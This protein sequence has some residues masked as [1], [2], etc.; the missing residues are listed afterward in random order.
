VEVWPILEKK[1]LLR[2]GLCVDNLNNISKDCNIS[3][4][5]F[6]RILD[7][8]VRNAKIGAYTFLR[9]GYIQN[10]KSIGRFCSIAKGLLIGMGEHPLT[11]LSSHPFQYESVFPFWENR[12]TLKP[13]LKK[14]K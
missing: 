9:G 13:K 14:S 6:V 7:T 8:Y 11:Y 12:R 2:K 5:P 10:V 1:E 4:E 3:I